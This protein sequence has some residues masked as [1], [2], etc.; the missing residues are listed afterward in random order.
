MSQSVLDSGDDASAAPSKAIGSILYLV[1]L[2]L[3]LLCLMP[4]DGV[5][6]D[7]EENYFALAAHAVSSGSVPPN[8]AIYDASLHRALTDWLLGGLIAAVGFESAQIIT[9]SLA[10]VAYA[11]LLR[12]LF[13][14]FGL[15]ALDAVLVILVFALLG[16]TLMGGEWLFRGFEAKVAAYGLVL[17]GLYRAASRRA[18]TGTVLLFAAATYFHFLVGGFWFVAA[19]AAR[20]TEDR[21]DL[22]PVASAAAGYLLI[23]APLFALIA[24]T[25]FA[26]ARGF[27]QP[28]DMPSPDV[29]YSIIR[30]PWHGAPFLSWESFRTQWL[31]GSLLAAVMLIACL[32]MA[33]K[34][35]A[36]RWRA[37]ALWLA[38][39]LAYLLLA[40]AA[41]F[42]E[43]ETGV[44]GK[45][46]LFRP[47]ALTLLL[48]LAFAMAWLGA[49]RPRRWTA[50]RLLALAAL[51]PFFLLGTAERIAADRQRAA[52]A[53][54]KRAL[55]DVLAQ[56]AAPGSV[57]LIDPQIEWSFLDFERRSGHPTLVT[58]KFMPTDDPGIVEWYR[59]M[60]FRRLVFAQGCP[61]HPAYPIDF[62]LTTPERAPVLV[63]SCGE[64]IY[65]TD[66]L[67]LWRVAR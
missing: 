8:T 37:T 18:L 53:G 17:A 4:P 6:S 44:L 10:A 52:L 48:C 42:A 25:R 40:L 41:S 61:Q 23:V 21:R 1:A 54:E 65:A 57:V 59:R 14:R 5:L 67:A 64:A 24:W 2:L 36:G 50:V 62:L 32:V 29:I 58:F 55:A 20:L 33:R 39:L 49:L 47:A 26:D 38:G 51:A 13:R 7:N 66:Q 22:R 43:R 30:E 31:P 27:V 19:M 11:F 9:R 45:F 15:S 16:Q 12:A 63:G 60:E 34:P 46:Y 35:K 56:N 3:L 28:A